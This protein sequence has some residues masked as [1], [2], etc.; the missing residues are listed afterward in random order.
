M[1]QLPIVHLNQ[2]FRAATKLAHWRGT[3]LQGIAGTSA[4]MRILLTLTLA[5]AFC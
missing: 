5:L 2:K 4:V 1:E 3:M